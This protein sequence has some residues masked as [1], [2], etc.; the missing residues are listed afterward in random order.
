[1]YHR[2][3]IT[4]GRLQYRAQRGRG[5]RIDRDALPLPCNPTVYR[6]CTESKGRGTGSCTGEEGVL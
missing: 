6:G 5:G 1:M 4:A 2:G 3:K